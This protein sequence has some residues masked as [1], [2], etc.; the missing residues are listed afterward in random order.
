MPWRID[1]HHAIFEASDATW[2]AAVDRT[3]GGCRLLGRD[4]E[5]V[6]SFASG[7]A[8]PNSGLAIRVNGAW[9]PLG[10]PD[11]AV[12][13]DD[14]LT[15]S[16]S[17]AEAS[18]CI[19]AD[20]ELGVRWSISAPGAESIALSLVAEAGEHYY[21][22]GERFNKL[23]QRGDLIELWVKNGA[24]GGDTYKPVPFIASSRGYGVAI[25]SSRRMFAALAHPTTPSV[26]TI[27]VEGSVIAE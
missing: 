7:N 23:D 15:L 6:A 21:G 19:D 3:T 5:P 22:L 2:S 18:A 13:A 26:S 4:G 1:G 12:I 17:H 11:E 9:Q 8:Y 25:D 14:T 24:S 10:T 16:W 27:T 20:P